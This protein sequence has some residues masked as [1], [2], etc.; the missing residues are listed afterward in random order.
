MFHD[1]IINALKNIYPLFYLE[2]SIRYIE[3][4]ISLLNFCTKKD[5]IFR[6]FL[7]LYKYI[8]NLWIVFFENLIET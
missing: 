4:A 2:F 7:C 5:R 8:F 6:S 3:I 1:F